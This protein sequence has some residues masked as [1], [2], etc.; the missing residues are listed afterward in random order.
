MKKLYTFT[1]TLTKIHHT[2]YQLD[3]GIKI[4][5]AKNPSSIEYV[6]TVIVKAGSVFEN[7]NN[8]PYG[9]AHFLEHI[10]TGNPNKLLKS[11]FDID[12]F[13]SGT[14]EDPEI[15]SNAFTTTKYIHF[16]SYGNEEGL[17]R[18]N[19]RIES[20]IDYPL[21]NIP[22]YIEKERK[23]ILA[24]Q[25]H[26]NKEKFDRNLQFSN[27]VYN[28]QENGFTHPLIGRKED[29]Q[30]ITSENIESFFKNQ[31]VAENTI[32]T[33]QNGRDL[34]QS[35]MKEIEKIGEI[36]QPRKTEDNFKD[37]DIV[38]KKRIYHFSDNQVEGV[39]LSILF[40]QKYTKKLDYKK[41]VLEF[42]FRSLMQKIS[43]DYLREKLGLIYSSNVFNIAHLNFKE[44]LIGYEITMQSRNFSKT[45]NGLNEIIEEKLEH[46]LKSK[47]GKVWFESIIS[48]YIFPRNVPYKADYA[49]RKGLALIE[50]EEVFELDKAVNSA[51]S[52]TIKDILE[53]S[54]SFFDT[55]P[56]FWI[57]S[58]REDDR[59]I[60][61]L[62]KSSLYNRF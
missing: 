37:P 33:I 2:I 22:K 26:M 49:E 32:I 61:M 16:Y 18:I 57:E 10:V 47:E 15:Y 25:S 11:K 27:F 24:E 4:L 42:L 56:L 35:E 28:N 8:V 31:F 51:L 30:N 3:N 6:L 5:H 36:F 34:T 46:F 58:D 55:T 23:V 20:I 48:G 50:D 54:K 9:T 44:R 14:K 60:K 59:Y 19:Q 41:E 45:V 38:R 17:K 39:S 29:I 13:E 52:I 1:D 53:Y 7:I 62:K 21:K 43:H 40:P 12:E